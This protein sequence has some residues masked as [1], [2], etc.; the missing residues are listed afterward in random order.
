MFGNPEPEAIAALLKK[1]RTVA[2]VGLSPKPGRDS[3][4]V[5]EEMQR[6]GHRIIP[7]RPATASILGEKAYPRLS[8][9]PADLLREI[10]VVD[11]FRAADHVPA[12]V[13]ECLS[14]GL[15]GKTLWLQLGV[16]HEAA[17]QKA[18]PGGMTVVMDRCIYVDYRNLVAR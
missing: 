12:L 9:I 10:D 11:V 18:A 5:A 1:A 16:V 3:H 13:E 7:V 15:E 6:F 14:L 8:D 4:H 17:A 2:V